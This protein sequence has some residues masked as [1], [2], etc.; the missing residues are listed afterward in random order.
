M[1]QWGNSP[2]DDVVQVDHDNGCSH[3]RELV[4]VLVCHRD[5]EDIAYLGSNMDQ[6]ETVAGI[7]DMRKP[8]A[9]ENGSEPGP[10]LHGF[11]NRAMVEKAVEELKK[12]RRGVHSVP[13]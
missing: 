10:G 11:G 6:M 7:R 12:Q 2:D 5:P 3:V 1:W 13:G 9:R 4:T 8:T